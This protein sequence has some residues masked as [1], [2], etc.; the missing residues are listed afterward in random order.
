[1]RYIFARFRGGGGD[2]RSRR[3]FRR[4][5]EDRHR[6]SGD[7]TGQYRRLTHESFDSI[8]RATFSLLC[9]TVEFIQQMACNAARYL[10]KTSR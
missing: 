8:Q 2:C 3:S 1:M 10:V 6:H 7:E 5:G 9:P 4:A